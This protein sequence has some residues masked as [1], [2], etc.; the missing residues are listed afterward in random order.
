MEH[1]H[2][3]EEWP[4]TGQKTAFRKRPPHVTHWLDSVVRGFFMT[5]LPFSCSRRSIRGRG[6]R[7]APGPRPDRRRYASPTADSFRSTFVPCPDPRRTGRVTPCCLPDAGDEPENSSS[8]TGLGDPGP[9]AFRPMILRCSC[10][11]YASRMPGMTLASRFDI[12][13]RRGEPRPLG[14][15]DSCARMAAGRCVVPAP[16]PHPARPDD[17]D[18]RLVLDPADDDA[19]LVPAGRCP[20]GEAGLLQ[21]PGLPGRLAPARRRR[22][23][24]RSSSSPSWGPSA[25]WRACMPRGWP[26]WRAPTRRRA[27]RSSASTPTSRTPPRRCRGSPGSTTCRS[28]CS[29]TW[30]TS[31]P[32]GWAS[33]GRPRSSSWTR[34]ASCAIAAGWTTSSA[35]ASTAR[36]RRAATSP[37][38]S[39]TCSPA[40]RS[41]RR[42]PSPPAAGS[43]GSRRPGGMRPSPTR[44]RWPAS[45]ATVA[46]PATARGRSRRSR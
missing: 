33:S 44:S 40:V 29:R 45:S 5:G 11:P 21:A 24:A 4:Q 1:V 12:G 25:R 6:S 38:R 7:P 23:R 26:S 43:A 14:F 39:T 19:G 9:T 41:P 22:A 32:T 3:Q 46:S 35:S 16:N 18:F 31:W 15:S 30:A 13:A 17:D 20:R 10:K 27:S 37:R 42:G 36:R 2:E 8:S 34:A 28:R